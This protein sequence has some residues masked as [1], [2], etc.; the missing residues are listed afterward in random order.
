MTT[1]AVSFPESEAN[2]GNLNE[3]QKMADGPM[4]LG[5]TSEDLLRLG[6]VLVGRRNHI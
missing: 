6:R 1:R 3:S 4:V 2:A 5:M